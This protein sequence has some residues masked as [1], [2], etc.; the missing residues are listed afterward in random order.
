MTDDLLIFAPEPVV[1]PLTKPAPPPWLILIVDDDPGVHAASRLALGDMVHAGRRLLLLSAYSAAEARQILAT[2]P[3]IALV[4]LDV[5]MESDQAG[6]ALARAIREEMGNHQIRIILRTGQPGQAPER[7]AVARYDINDYRAK[8]ELTATRLWTSVLTALRTYEQIRALEGNRGGLAHLL[9][10]TARLLGERDSGRFA[11]GVVESLIPLAGV[12]AGVLVVRV[13]QVNGEARGEPR[14]LAGR[15]P[16]TGQTSAALASLPPGPLSHLV[17]AEICQQVTQS[18]ARPDGMSEG[19]WLAVHAPLSPSMAIIIHLSGL[20]PEQMPDMGMILL[21][22]RTIAMGLDNALLVEQLSRDQSHDRI[23]GLLNRAGLVRAVEAEIAALDRRDVESCAVAVID[24]RRFRDI[25]QELGAHWGDRLLEI[26]AQR[27]R[28]SAGAGARCARLGGDRFTILLPSGLAREMAC[29]RVRAIADAVCQPVTLDGRE[30]HPMAVP[31]L[32]WCGLSGRHAEELLS[33]AE[34]SMQMAK[35]SYGRLQ[36]IVIGID[37]AGERLGLMSDLGAALRESQFELYYQPIVEA[38]T[39]RVVAFEALV[40]WNHPARGIVV[41][42][43]FIPAAEETGLIV[44]IG[45]WAMREAALRTAAWSRAAGRPVWVSVNIS[46]AQLSEPGFLEHVRQVITDVGVDPSLLKLEVTESTIIGDPAHA[47]DILA[48][49]RELGV[50]LC[51]DDFGTGYSN[52]SYLQ[53][54]PFDL[55]K[56]DRA[57][58]Q[59]MMDRYESRTILR[60]M[61]VLAQQLS[62]EVVAEG[63]ETMEQADE[64][65]RLGCGYLQGYLYG[66]PM[67]V[68][69]AEALLA[70]PSAAKS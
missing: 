58:V 45:T 33:R 68:A 29:D 40:R 65:A 8:D 9:E 20:G 31:G 57:F 49:L 26:T 1:A 46:A 50:R 13:D 69:Q 25:N 63:V 35:R 53:T 2:H 60:T 34:E 24:L 52:L 19:T 39:R 4:L 16:V 56:V 61:L 18:L 41:P 64:L 30:W 32:A 11:A 15:L 21:F 38:Q 59:S 14:L 47:A 17:P 5:V 6:L 51:M 7:E 70:L 37:G 44:P 36:E 67:P 43:A 55:L 22:A 48:G 62:L 12:G 42:A 28:A 54:L 27:L 3:D 23:T 10:A 66:K